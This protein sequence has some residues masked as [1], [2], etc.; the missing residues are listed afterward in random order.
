[1]NTQDYVANLEEKDCLASRYK[2]LSYNL[3]TVVTI[4]TT[5]LEL[6]FLVK[7][8]FPAKTPTSSD[9]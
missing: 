8:R 5:I 3:A 7:L 9:V 1:M 2:V 4:V 6:R